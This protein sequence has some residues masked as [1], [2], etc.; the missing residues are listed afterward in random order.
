[1]RLI[2]YWSK[3]TSNHCILLCKNRNMNSRNIT[4]SCIKTTSA[5]RLLH[6]MKTELQNNNVK[7]QTMWDKLI[8]YAPHFYITQHFPYSESSSSPPE[9]VTSCEQ[10]VHKT[11]RETEDSSHLNLPWNERKTLGSGGE[12]DETKETTSRRTGTS[13][14]ADLPMTSDLESEVQ[15][16]KRTKYNSTRHNTTRGDLKVQNFEK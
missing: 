16:V 2:L 6:Y 1:M 8:S 15:V 14:P 5:E 7:R 10:E 4:G 13:D 12:K 11:E 3:K 9:E